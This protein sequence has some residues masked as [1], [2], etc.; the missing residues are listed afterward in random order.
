MSKSTS[1]DY[2]IM[3]NRLIAVVEEQATT[4]IR[5]AFSTSVREA[6]DLSAGLF[7][8]KGR[9]IA[10]AVTGTPGHVNAMAE[11]VSHFISEIGYENM[12]DKD[13][14]VTNDP[15]MGTGHLHDITMVSPV[16][17]AGV[18]IG[19]F[20]CTAHVVDIGGRGFGPDSGEVY[21]EGLLIPIM[22]FAD[23]GEV[24]RVLIQFV[25]ANTRAPDQVV[26][27]IYSLAACNEA[28]ERRLQT[29]L[30][31]F[32]INDIR[33]L[34][35]FII[36]TSRKATCAA[37]RKVPDGSYRY[38]MVVD[39]FEASVTMKVRLDIDGEKL[40]A[41]FA[42]T[43]GM[44]KFGVNC[45]EVYT[46]AY[47]CYGLKCAIAASVPN[48]AGSL[49]PFHI[50]APEGSILAARRPAPV[51]TRHVMG[52]LVPDVVLGALHSA[53]PNV[54]PAEGASA[55]WNIQISARPCDPDSELPNKEVLMFNSGG[56]GARPALD[57]LSA[58]AFPSGVSTMSVEATE[59]VG[60]ITVWRKELRKGSGGAGKFRGGLGQIIEIEPRAGYDL[61]VNAMFDR[62]DYA[63]RG[64][65]GGGDGAAGKVELAD[66][67]ALKPKGR[68]FIKNGHRLRLSLPGG[69]G[70][71]LPEHRDPSAVQKDLESDFITENQAQSDYK[72]T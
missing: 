5:T 58:T 42:G 64:R 70:Y 36:E 45:P 8:Q 24:E 3:W 16:F 33:Y 40:I 25:R 18:L 10:Q 69:G 68:Q 30:D 50:R 60:P 1:V 7:D 28:G 67:T 11:S 53:L 43:S 19:F 71:G 35:D 22:K 65:E 26:G 52:H 46:R 41:D 12:Y 32:E 9:M 55:L 56:T 6:G 38:S 51:S 61:Y 27:D 72:Y 17:R 37:I 54:V 29:M 13:A 31:E 62:V 15:W 49:E 47:A 63:A 66:G 39:G 21:E 2:Q 44:S 23:R 48:N 4:L 14:Y 59:Q 57:G 20:A 34:S